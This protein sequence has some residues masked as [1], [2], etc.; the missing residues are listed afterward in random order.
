MDNN[1]GQE[2]IQYW[3]EK[4]PD[5]KTRNVMGTN[6]APIYGTLAIAFLETRLYENSEEKLGVTN[7]TKLEYWDVN[8]CNENELCTMLTDLCPNITFTMEA[9]S[10]RINFLDIQL[11]VAQDKLIT[12]IYYQPTDTSKYVHFKSR[13]PKHTLINIPFNLARRLCTTSDESTTL[14][15][16]LEELQEMLLHLDCPLT[17][18]KKGI[19]QAKNIPQQT[20]HSNIEKENTEDLL[21]FISTNNPRNPNVFSIIKESLPIVKT[22]NQNE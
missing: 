12:D 11:L 1:L 21:T 3:L 9:N 4:Y 16:R 22:I 7:R 8:I 14:E 18:I 2:A 17:L 5:I 19:E 10:S 6:W 20:L 13:H 15:T